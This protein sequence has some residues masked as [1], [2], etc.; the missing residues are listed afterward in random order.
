VGK[1][2]VMEAIR[3]SRDMGMTGEALTDLRREMAELGQSMGAAGLAIVDW[4]RE[5][6]QEIKRAEEQRQQATTFMTSL[7]ASCEGT[8]FKMA[9]YTMR[10]D[11][12]LLE[13]EKKAMRRTWQHLVFFLPVLFLGSL[14]SGFWGWKMGDMSRQK[15]AE[16]VAQVHSEREEFGEYLLLN[17]PKVTQKYWRDFQSWRA[18]KE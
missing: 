17:Q 16:R 18:K 14:L 11:Q 12:M 4:Q 9:T 13:I 10:V 3:R 7:Q 8:L 5:H 2:N 15:E 6:T 1:E